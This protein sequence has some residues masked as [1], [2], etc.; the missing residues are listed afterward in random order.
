MKSILITFDQAYYER[1]VDMLERNNCRGFTAWQEVQ[2]RG[3]IKGEPHY[4]S[5]AWPSLASAIITVVED[6]R[7]ESVLKILHEMDL[8]TPKL[9]LRAFVWNIEQTI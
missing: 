8:A 5:H 4:G 6:N 3:S 2:G 7:V 9:G 1:I